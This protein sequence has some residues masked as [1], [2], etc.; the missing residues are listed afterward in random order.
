ME[1]EGEEML[2]MD[3]LCEQLWREALSGNWEAARIIFDVL[4]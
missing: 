2:R 3:I 4:K 1:F